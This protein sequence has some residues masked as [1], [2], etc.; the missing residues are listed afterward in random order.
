MTLIVSILTN[1][2][3]FIVSDKMHS[4]DGTKDKPVTGTAKLGGLTVNFSTPKL[5]VTTGTKN[6]KISENVCVGG[7]GDFAKVQEYLKLIDGCNENNIINGTYSYYV[8]KK[9]NAPDQLLILRKVGEERFVDAFYHNIKDEMF[10]F[11]NCM[12]MINEINLGVMAIGSGGPLFMN[13]YQHIREKSIEEYK[14]SIKNGKYDEWE[15]QFIAKIANMF[16]DVSKYDDAVST[17]IDIT[18]I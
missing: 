18:S 7:A 12:F 8:E 11:I 3:G 1:E 10:S 6:Y 14:D 5:R 9:Q 15:T 13:M 17:E 4:V 16:S 2:R